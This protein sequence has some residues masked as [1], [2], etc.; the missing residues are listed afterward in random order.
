[1]ERL[2]LDLSFDVDGT[3]DHQDHRNK[4]EDYVR[5]VQSKGTI[6]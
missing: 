1:M 6:K 4:I 3:G 5:E 2:I